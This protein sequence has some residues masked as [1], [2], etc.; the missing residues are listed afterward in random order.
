MSL[1]PG[2]E[3]FHQHL[4][5]LSKLCAQELDETT[6]RIYDE[7]LSARYPYPRLTEA[8]HQIIITRRSRDPFPSCQD[9]EEQINPRA[10]ARLDAD[11][12]AAIL[13][14]LV[15]RKGR[16]WRSSDELRALAGDIGAL[17]VG[18]MGGWYS[19]AEQCG[20]TKNL[21]T[22]RAQIRDLSLAIIQAAKAGKVL[23]PPQLEHHAP[24][25]AAL[26]QMKGM[27]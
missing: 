26:L 6:I 21:E 23:H 22:F 8:L 20:D 2:E 24:K 14:K 1:K 12:V 7:H 9:I 10:N 19:F 17:V 13:I 11:R 3:S 16:N 4:A 25:V 18:E 15:R 27:D 5:V